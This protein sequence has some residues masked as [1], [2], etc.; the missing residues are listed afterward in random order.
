MLFFFLGLDSLKSQYFFSSHSLNSSSN[1]ADEIQKFSLLFVE[2]DVCWLLWFSALIESNSITLFCL[3]QL[4]AVLRSLACCYF[5]VA[6]APCRCSAV[7]WQIKAQLIRSSGRLS[8]RRISGSSV[9][10]PCGRFLENHR[11]GNYKGMRGNFGL[12]F[13]SPKYVQDVFF[14][15]F[16]RMEAVFLGCSVTW[17]Q[18]SDENVSLGRHFRNVCAA[19]WIFF[20]AGEKKKKKTHSKQNISEMF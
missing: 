13:D 16:L 4:R 14:V 12:S 8:P 5:A 7:Q 18:F 3:W 15:F 19:I 17:C 10:V 20:S 2:V 1:A 9:H 11:A 6:V